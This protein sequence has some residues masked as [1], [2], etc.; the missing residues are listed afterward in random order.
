MQIQLTGFLD[1]DTPTF[2]KDLWR[3]LLSAQTSPQ[4]VPKELLEAKKMELMQEK[5][6]GA[7]TGA[8]SREPLLTSQNRSKRTGLPKRPANDERNS[9]VETVVEVV[10]VAG[11][12]AA[13]RGVAA[14]MIEIGAALV[15][16]DRVR[17]LASAIEE[18]VVDGEGPAAAVGETHTFPEE[19]RPAVAVD[20]AIPDDADPGLEL[21]PCRLA[22][23]PPG[24][25]RAARALTAA[26]GPLLGHPAPY[27]A[28]DAHDPVPARP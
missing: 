12:A 19:V 17:R 28:D 16:G 7:R 20:I 3:L 24:L 13:T 26:G 8:L 22:L 25:A 27:H 9:S 18:T 21:A 23:S 14:V 10:G 6:G 1:K 5:V 15:A 4:G 2:C 11:R